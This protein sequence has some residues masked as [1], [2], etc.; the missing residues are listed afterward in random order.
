M[1]CTE[2]KSNEI[3]AI[4]VLL[5]QIAVAGCIITINVVG[6]QYET[7]EKIVKKEAGYVFPLKGNWETLHEEVKEHWDI[8]GFNKSGAQAEYIKFRCV[9]HMRKS[10]GVKKPATMR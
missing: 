3:T 4:P 8:P 1:Y 10:M 7:A 9:S 5:E 2:E 6:C